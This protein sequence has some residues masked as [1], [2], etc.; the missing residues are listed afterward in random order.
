[1]HNINRQNQNLRLFEYGKCYRLTGKTSSD[2]TLAGYFEDRRIALFLTG[3]RSEPSW[4]AT[5]EKISYFH[6]KAMC[7]KVIEKLGIEVNSLSIQAIEG[8]DDIFTGGLSYSFNKTL[9]IEIGLVNPKLLKQFDIGQEVLFAELRWEE[10]LKLYN[11]TIRFKEMP[12]FPEVRR[13]LALLI[14]QSVEF[15]DIKNIALQTEKK[16]LKRINLFDFY[17]GKG[18]AEGKKSYGVSFYLQDETK[19]L[20]D[21]EIDRI[22]SKI[23]D[24]LLKEFKADLR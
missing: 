2:N 12:K 16:L 23:S 1:L 17:T 8:R 13:D 14:D 3:N 6:L 5:E 18:I 21:N 20:T 19:T 10:L 7:E 4:T 11:S 22:M 9:L 15:A 24:R